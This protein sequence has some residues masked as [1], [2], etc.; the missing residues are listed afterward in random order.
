[1]SDDPGQG[2]AKGPT[3]I[4]GVGAS[5][6]GLEAVTA[7]LR[8]LTAG[9][10]LVM[11]VVQHLEA[12]RES[13]LVEILARATPLHVVVAADGQ[14]IEAGHVYVIPPSSYLEVS[15]ATLHVTPRP[16]GGEP[17]L[18]ID[19][20]L[21]SLAEVRGRDAAGVI[22]SGTGTDGA[23]GIQAIRA[24]AG[25]TFAQD[26]TARFDGMPRAAIATGS[27][28][29]V[30]SPAAIAGA[31]SELA[32]LSS[33]GDAPAPDE[34]EL[35]GVLSLL[36]RAT[37]VDFAGYKRTTVVRRIRRRL[38]VH[39]LSSLAEYAR[40]LQD[41]AAEADEL[42]EEL[43]VHVTSFFRDPA[44]FTALETLV[45]PRLVEGRARDA[46]IRVWVPGCSTGEE[47]Y[48]LAIM[49]LELLARE[50]LDVPIKVFATDLSRRAIEQARQGKY[51]EVVASQVSPA[52]LA[53]FFVQTGAGY[54][55]TRELRDQC[56][57]A[58]QDL[59]RDPPFSN[60]DLISCRNLMIYLAPTLQQRVLPIF[61]YAL[62]PGGHLVLGRAESLSAFEGFDPVD[63]PNKI[64]V[65]TARRPR[66]LEP[67]G[68]HDWAVPSVADASREHP[69]K[70]VDLV[71][72]VD[73][74]ILA[75]CAPP[76]VVVAEDLT[77]VQFRGQTG[78]F[79]EPVPGVASLGLLRLARE[80]LRPAL[81]EALD[82][83]RRTGARSRAEGVRLREADG[84]RWVDLEVLPVAA[85][86]RQPRHYVVLFRAASPPPTGSGPADVAGA[87]SEVLGREL[88]STRAYLQSV[89]EQLEATNEDLRAANE[90][91]VSSN[92]ELQ[93]TNEELQ[94]AQEELQATNEEL[95]TVNDELTDR[96]AETS[97]LNDD[98]TNVLTS[99]GMPT[100]LL[101]RDGA[102]R[103]FTPA[104]ATLW[105]L[106]A[107][108]V[109]RQFSDIKP[110]L[111]DPDLVAATASALAGQT[112]ADRTVQDEQGRW[113]QLAVRSYV[114][115]DHRLDGTVVT[116]VDVDPLKRG[117]QLLRDARDYAQAI[118]DTVREP[119]LVLD[120]ELCVRSAN[121]SYYELFQVTPAD[122]VDRHI[123]ELLDGA[124]RDAELRRYL[125]AVVGGTPGDGARLESD[126][127]AVRRAL[128]LHANRIPRGLHGGPLV[129]V[130]V[131]DV[132]RRER[133]HQARESAGRVLREV[134][135]TSATAEG[136]LIVDRR[137]KV[138]F[139]NRTAKQMFGYD[140]GELVGR[141]ID[142]LLPEQLRRVHEEHRRLFHEAPQPRPMLKGRTVSGRRKDGAEIP[143]EVALGLV[144]DDTGP[145]VVAI[146]TD[147]AARR[148][149]DAQI[150]AYEE[151][152]G[153]MAF[154]T[155]VAQ[156]R[157]RR[158]IAADLHDHVGQEL[159]LLQI[160]LTAVRDTVT[161]DARRSVVECIGMVEQSIEETRALMFELSPPVLHD[162]GLKAA[163]GWLAE[164]LAARHGITVS[165]EGV[166]P[167][168]LDG[169]VASVLF[170]VV[171]E[172]LTNVVKHARSSL[173][174]VTFR[175][176]GDH[177]VVDVEDRGVGFDAAI[178]GTRAHQGFGLFSVREQVGRLGGTFELASSTDAG[179]R[180]SLRVPLAATAAKDSRETE[181]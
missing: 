164:Q 44:V 108:D 107:T 85:S 68:R 38:A 154:D 82:E 168:G 13:S 71:Q 96:N 53:R 14:P 117:E 61:H 56:V 78:P 19:R 101:G 88:S 52:A 81:R 145:L 28:E 158:R 134:L 161:G 77:I 137:G 172:L 99:T 87:A 102:I 132:T 97:R 83:A 179:T 163:V 130:S 58:R 40:L 149:A 136:I 109:G 176:D 42:G 23:R 178:L 126:Q 67:R 11:I 12:H 146:C 92:E 74:A 116:V 104:A 35:G 10:G 48:S 135:A 118:V 30:G 37:G 170:R 29:T 155:A 169:D 144:E 4:V 165:V 147:V 129:L 167:L 180:V 31:L 45:F 105:N 173:A 21:A 124:W 5:A 7:L 62:R 33:R 166:D 113:H 122:T 127:G 32:E 98:L 16:E 128:V 79:L 156:E 2:E 93:S 181:P 125:Q 49:L 131:E 18:P 174:V 36:R 63:A 24:R 8:G 140:P 65:R 64:F 76:G 60:L 138:V 94:T 100:L 69:V 121:R 27:V 115:S 91:V 80:E 50:R 114:T 39:R 54:Q 55:V 22:L 151:K 143:I 160:R 15:G 110:R 34:E 70:Q 139:A 66:P 133:A 90:E 103:R 106:L 9:A 148:A 75:A 57:F 171:R 6:G 84:E 177:L 119:L 111:S 3:L 157:E 59:T 159:A 153:E 162:L 46:P 43:L 25:A 20:L 86:P 175:R 142:E 112:P 51:G 89:I 72:E 120:E 17:F 47:P 141:S 26:E 152:L 123:D 41:D 95:R 1:M 150:H 73:R